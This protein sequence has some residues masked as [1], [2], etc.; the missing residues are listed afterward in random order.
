MKGFGPLL[1]TDKLLAHS[2]MDAL[3]DSTHKVVCAGL[4]ISGPGCL[5]EGGG[6]A[7]VGTCTK[8]VVHGRCRPFF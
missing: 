3:W 1:C 6:G 4:G 8:P 5:G 7:A 2:N